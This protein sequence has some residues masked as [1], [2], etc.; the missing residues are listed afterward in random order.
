MA[1][2]SDKPEAKA[3]APAKPPEPDLRGKSVEEQARLLRA[4]SA[5]AYTSILHPGDQKIRNISLAIT[6]GVHALIGVIGYFWVQ[7]LSKADVVELTGPVSIQKVVIPPPPPPELQQI[8]RTEIEIK[9]PLPDP[10]P[11]KP[12]PIVEEEEVII[13]PDSSV[14]LDLAD[15]GDVE[16]PPAPSGPLIAGVDATMPVLIPGTRVEPVYP[17][18][19][20]RTG[21]EGKV[22]MQAV[23]HKD[24]TVGDIQVLRAPQPD[25]GFS[26]AAKEAVV[27]WRYQPGKQGDRPVDVIFT[28]VVDFRID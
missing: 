14:P 5:G 19:A 8:Q 9:V 7:N 18:M 27:Q 17:E 24:G 22:I 20:R 26:E 28:I 12:E 2:K 6:I 4:G 3:A 16:A 25:L 11:D 13:I 21:V 23:I 10:E 15:F 1:D